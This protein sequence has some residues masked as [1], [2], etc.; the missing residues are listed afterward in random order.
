MIL[1]IDLVLIRNCAAGSSLLRPKYQ[2]SS[3]GSAY[4]YWFSS[5]LKLCSQ[6]AAG[7]ASNGMIIQGMHTMV[8]QTLMPP[9]QP[10]FATRPDV[11]G[12]YLTHAHGHRS[13]VFLC[14]SNYVPCPSRILHPTHLQTT[15]F[16]PNM[17][18]QTRCVW[19][20]PFATKPDV[21]DLYPTHAHC[22]RSTRPDVSDVYYTHAHGH[23]STLV[24]CKSNYLLVPHGFCSRNT[25]SIPHW[26]SPRIPWFCRHWLS[27]TQHS[28][29]DPM[30]LMS[31]PPMHI[32]TDRNQTRRVWCL[33]HPCT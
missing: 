4:P 28:Q 32:V 2:E 5:E 23:R 27:F 6:L 8:L 11:S 7:S 10:T 31:I 26:L 33:S 16:Q 18:N 13:T 30:C 3:Y 15:H 1:R 25:T 22:H 17:C 9:S 14:K 29:P 24:L 12:V 20:C 19:W 21:S